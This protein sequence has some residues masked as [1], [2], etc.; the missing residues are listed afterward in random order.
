MLKKIIILEGVKPGAVINMVPFFVL[1]YYW[2]DLDKF[3]MDFL[4]MSH[5]T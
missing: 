4:C 2:S 3:I 5:K 1:E